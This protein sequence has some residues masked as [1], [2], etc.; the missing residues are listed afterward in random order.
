LLDPLP[1]FEKHFTQFIC[2]PRFAPP[3]IPKDFRG[4]VLRRRPGTR[5]SGAISPDMELD[6]HPG[7]SDSTSAGLS[8]GSQSQ[9]MARRNNPEENELHSGNSFGAVVDAR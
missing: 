2:R 3:T 9:P 4:F 5:V 8:A 1:D 6:C 7:T